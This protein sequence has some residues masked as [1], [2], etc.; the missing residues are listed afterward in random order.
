MITNSDPLPR[1]LMAR[2]GRTAAGQVVEHVEARLVA[3]REPSFRGQ[4]AGRDLRPGLEREVALDVLRQLGAAADAPP[5]EANVHELIPGALAVCAAGLQTPGLDGTAMA[6]KPDGGL[7]GVGLLLCNKDSRSERDL[8]CVQCD[9]SIT[10]RQ[11]D[12]VV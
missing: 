3:S 2:F 1:A 10:E 4:V 5:L 7:T 12:N 9:Q 8:V 11:I 6:A